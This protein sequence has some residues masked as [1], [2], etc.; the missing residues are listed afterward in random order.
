[1]IGCPTCLSTYVFAYLRLRRFGGVASVA[2]WAGKCL[3]GVEDE[4]Q[5]SLQKCKPKFED[6]LKYTETDNGI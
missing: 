6:L 5:I 3:A 1:M 2:G 4:I